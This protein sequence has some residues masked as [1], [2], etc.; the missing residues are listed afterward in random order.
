MKMFPKGI[1]IIVFLLL[2]I[3]NFSFILK[4]HSLQPGMDCRIYMQSKNGHCIGL[5]VIFLC[6]CL[7][8]FCLF[9]PGQVH[10][11]VLEDYDLLKVKVNS[12]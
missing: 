7:W 6:M 8:S 9:A 1:A 5:R 2:Y 3:F 12:T 11:F 10:S 4:I